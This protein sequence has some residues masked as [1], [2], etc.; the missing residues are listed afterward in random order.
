MDLNLKKNELVFFDSC[1]SEDSFPAICTRFKNNFELLGSPIGDAT[2]CTQFVNRFVDKRVVHSLQALQLVDDAQV[3]HYLL[4]LCTS[5]CKVIH[6]LRTVP[7]LFCRDALV[8]FDRKIKQAFG[9]VLGIVLDNS[10]EQ[11][12]LPISMAGF[13]LRSAVDHA[14]GAYLASV[15][16]AAKL[17]SWDAE[18]ATGF[19][20]ALLDIS[21]RTN[22]QFTPLSICSEPPKQHTLS[23]AID[24]RRWEQLFERS[25]PFDRARLR[26]AGAP[27]ASSWLGVIPS[28]QFNQVF[29]SQQYTTLLKFW[30]GHELFPADAVCPACGDYN[31]R[32]GYHG[33]TC[34]SG[35]SL[36]VRHNAL[37]E[38]YLHFCKIA[39]LPA[40]REVPALLANLADRPA[41]V[42]VLPA[43]GIDRPA[44][45][46]F[47][48]TNTL[49]TKTIHIAGVRV[50]EAA[51]V[52][53]DTVKNPRYKFM[54]AEAGMD[55][56]PMVVDCFGAWGPSANEAFALLSKAAA[57]HENVSGNR[58]NGHILRSM[59]VTLQRHNA[60]ALLARS[61]ATP[62]LE[63]IPWL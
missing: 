59:S 53:E 51:K 2:H 19:T 16:N 20:E 25:V 40:E 56:I 48:V 37:R 58:A 55:F 1:D 49:Q 28:Y 6:L 30:L 36:G 63:V 24:K 61:P 14:S 38:V 35:G 17:D 22:L 11:I 23:A 43:H 10:W 29:T 7:T 50:G 13:G 44:C 33:L 12:A 54:C 3:G 15:T 5:I 26:S 45:I 8:D 52:Y 18:E 9:V 60:R 47:A 39:R 34:R 31:D 32:F 41:D 62:E 4:R 46:D 27:G 42:L 21:T 57:S